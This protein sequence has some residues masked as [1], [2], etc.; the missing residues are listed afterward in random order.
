MT[1]FDVDIDHRAQE[2]HDLEE[3]GMILFD[4]SALDE[5]SVFTIP[6][7][8]STPQKR[9]TRS[10]P[11]PPWSRRSSPRPSWSRKQGG[12]VSQAAK[13]RKPRESNSSETGRD[14]HQ[15]ESASEQPKI[16]TPRFLSWAS[17]SKV[18][19][20]YDQSS[21][22]G[23]VDYS[24]RVLDSMHD[25]LGSHT[26]LEHT[27]RAH[28]YKWSR[29]IYRVELLRQRPSLQ[30][31]GERDT[32]ETPVSALPT[33]QKT[34]E[35]STSS[36]QVNSVSTTGATDSIHA[37][38][39]QECEKLAQDMFK[40]VSE[41]IDYFIPLTTTHSILERCWGA[42]EV[43]LKV[44]ILPTSYFQAHPNAFSSW[45]K[46]CVCLIIHRTPSQHSGSSATSPNSWVT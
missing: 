1:R 43:I 29:E 32:P 45:T 42:F 8:R 15:E 16:N 31:A 25:L 11:K 5:A 46:L 6:E 40:H 17:P 12:N 35:P 44:R 27:T 33:A 13:P 37:R 39:L 24:V 4:H 38:V 18:K 20:Y 28:V 23:P 19:G 41:I 7:P 30:A 3:R 34:T 14:S 26:R 10:S 36:D 2:A 9:R 21:N 22:T